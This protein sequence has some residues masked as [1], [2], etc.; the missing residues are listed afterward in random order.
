MIKVISGGQTGVDRAALD[1]AIFCDLE[2]GG[3]CPKGRRAEDGVIPVHYSLKETPTSDYAQRTKWN[4][5]KGNATLVLTTGPLGGGTAL[6]LRLAQERR[7]DHLIAHPGR[8]SD[9][10]RVVDWV[11]R[12]QIR[13]LNVAGPRESTLPG[14]YA[15]SYEFLTAVFA[16]FIPGFE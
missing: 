5:L 13:I 7:K 1:A 6:T 2:T 15:R 11:R 4:I 10:A 8:N 9:I 12:R 3:W 16:L 14:I